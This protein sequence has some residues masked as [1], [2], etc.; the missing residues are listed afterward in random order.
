MDFRKW[1]WRDIR[2]SMV[3][4]TRNLCSAINPS[5]VHTLGEHTPGFMLR[6]LGIWGLG[7]LL[8]G[9][10]VICIEGRES[11]GHSLPPP[12]IPAGLRFEHA[13]FGLQ[14]RPP[15]PW[16]IWQKNVIYNF[17]MMQCNHHQSSTSELPHYVHWVLYVNFCSVCD[18]LL[19]FFNLQKKLLH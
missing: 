4:H 15:P 10:S 14:V 7:A 2:P 13:T 1:K 5:N 16:D 3:T 19:L 12:T 18:L 17:F 8:K 6:R 11:A 9:T